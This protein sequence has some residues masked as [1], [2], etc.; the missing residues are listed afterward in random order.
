MPTRHQLRQRDL[1]ALSS[2]S[3]PAPIEPREGARVI[4]APHW[5]AP[6]VPRTG[7]LVR[8]VLQ[9]GEPLRWG[10]GSLT[11]PTWLVRQT[12]FLP[13]AGE[14]GKLLEGT[15]IVKVGRPYLTAIEPA[16][17]ADD[18]AVEAFREL[19]RAAR[20]EQCAGWFPATPDGQRRARRFVESAP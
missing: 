17:G 19:W 14:R 18:A 10:S 6:G 12:E 1:D 2:D 20:A 15:D 13:E 4:F 11:G 16:D 3:P 7:V 9:D 8:P 5:L